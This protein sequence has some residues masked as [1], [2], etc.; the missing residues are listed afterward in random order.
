MVRNRGYLGKSMKSSNSVIYR[1]DFTINRQLISQ[2]DFAGVLEN[3]PVR[4]L[5]LG[6]EIPSGVIVGRTDNDDNTQTV[7][8]L[9]G[10]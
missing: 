3:W 2:Y 8:D 1:M 7:M 5:Y 9:L 6:E 10:I 4:C